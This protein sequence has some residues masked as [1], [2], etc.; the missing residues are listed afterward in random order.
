MENSITKDYVTEKLWQVR[1]NARNDRDRALD[2]FPRTTLPVPASTGPACAILRRPCC[3]ICRLGV[4]SP[5]AACQPH[6]P[7]LAC[8]QALEAGC[9]P[10]YMGPHNINDFL[11]DPNAIVDYHKLGSPEKLMAVSGPPGCGAGQPCA[12]SRF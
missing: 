9:L 10:V 7:F 12:A 3:S 1:G 8:A 5:R 2:C 6:S 11:P 4:A